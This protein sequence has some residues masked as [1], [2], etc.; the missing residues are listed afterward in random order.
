MADKNWQA[1]GKNSIPALAVLCLVATVVPL[2]LAC[3]ASPAFAPST[4]LG[5]F[6]PSTV[7]ELLIG[8]I[9]VASFLGSVGLWV[10]SALRKARRSQ[11]RRNAFISTALNHLHQGVVMTDPSGRVV[12]CND[13]YLELYGLS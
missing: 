7:W 1:G 4:Y 11:L 3:A 6:D 8:G 9:V 12:F 13:Q 5:E 10:L 2:R